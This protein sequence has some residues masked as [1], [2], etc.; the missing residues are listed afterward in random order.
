MSNVLT[1]FGTRPRGDVVVIPKGG[2]IVYDPRGTILLDGAGNPVHNGEASNSAI[3]VDPEQWTA[4]ATWENTSEFPIET[5]ATN[6][7]V[8]P[9][10]RRDNVPCQT[11]FIYNA[12]LPA[13]H[14]SALMPV[15]QYGPSAAGGGN[16]WGVATWYITPKFVYHTCLTPV[17][18]G[19]PLDATIHLTHIRS[20][21]G[22]RNPPPTTY[23][24][25]ARFK[26]IDETVV[27]V[28]ASKELKLID[29]IFEAH[30]APSPD[31]YP[32][33]V[34]LFYPTNVSLT[35]KLFWKIGGEKD[36]KVAVDVNTARN[37][38]IIFT[39]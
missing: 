14:T 22:Q 17:E 24:Y 3:D 11:L 10:P 28:R 18:I 1:P 35:P 36:V 12:A 6:F 30:N 8:P 20:Y 26:G 9:Y 4:Y 34:T 19:D 15:L 23:D 25:T 13:D 5:F 2:Q 33:G 7:R 21:V 31:Y 37:G 16:Y 38:E 32:P 27:N 39:Y 29:L